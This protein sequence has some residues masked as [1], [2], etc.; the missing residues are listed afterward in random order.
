MGFDCIHPFRNETD[1]LSDSEDVRIH[2]EGIPFQ[3][4]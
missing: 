1:T 3:A 4:E 2:R